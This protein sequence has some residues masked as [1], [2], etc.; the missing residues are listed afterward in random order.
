[1]SSATFVHQ[2]IYKSALARRMACWLDAIPHPPV[3]MEIASDRVAVA[4]WGRSGALEAFAVELLA[5]GTV[6][7]SAVE[8]NLVNPAAAKSAVGRAC[9]RVRTRAEEAALILPDP[10]IRVFVQHFEDFPRSSEEAIPLLRWKLK[11]S[12]PFEAD[13]TIIS[14]FRQAPREAGVDIVTAL[15]RLRIIREYESLAEG[16]GL[17]P[18]VVLSSSL[19]ALALLDGEKPVL[20]ARISGSALTTAIVFSGLLC[21][22]RCTELPAYGASLTPQM[23]LE[24]IFPVA[25]YYQDTWHE[26][27]SSVR[28]AGLGARFAE[29]VRPLEQEFHCDV[30]SL[31]N[32]AHSEGRIKDDARQLADRDLEGL[33]GWMLHRN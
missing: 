10:V 21:G 28:I 26:G 19:A 3:A 14:Y 13:E 6:I 24:E 9:D 23:L 5:E 32:T 31:L 33:V 12:V 25:A 4:R 17:E 8:T 11:K 22:Y 29:F 20:F 30:K 2:G 1:M 18:G 16:V 7:P 27:I 15:A